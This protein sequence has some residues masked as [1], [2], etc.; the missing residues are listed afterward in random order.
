MYEHDSHPGQWTMTILA[1]F[2]SPPNLR[3][4]HMKSEQHCLEAS[5]EKSFEI[6]NIF[7]I[8][9]Y[10][11]HTNAQGS[12]IDLAVKRSNVNVQQLF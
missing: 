5:E 8:Q 11:T 4:L 1:I 10:G 9:M 7:P 6:L 3:R 2:C 12:K